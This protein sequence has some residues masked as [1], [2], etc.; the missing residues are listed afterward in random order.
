MPERVFLNAL[1]NIAEE[2]HR[3]GGTFQACIQC[4]RLAASGDCEEL[5]ATRREGFGDQVSPIRRTI[6]NDDDFDELLGVVQSEEILQLFS[7]KVRTVVNS[8][9]DTDGRSV[10]LAFLDGRQRFGQHTQ[11]ER[12]AQQKV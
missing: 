9:K 5:D 8:H 7:K 12:V 4:R 10:R 6:G 1:A 11:Q 3:S 2:N